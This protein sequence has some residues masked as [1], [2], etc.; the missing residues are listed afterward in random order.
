[1]Y[2]AETEPTIYQFSMREKIELICKYPNHQID[3]IQLNLID[4]S[5][6]T[7]TNTSKKIKPGPNLRVY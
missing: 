3:W 4:G 6:S 7:C 5:I 2:Y 1:M